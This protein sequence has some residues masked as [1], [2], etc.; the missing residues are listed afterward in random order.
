[1]AGRVELYDPTVSSNDGV[2]AAHSTYRLIFQDLPKALPESSG[3][4]ELSSVNIIADSYSQ[5]FWCALRAQARI[6]R[7]NREGAKDARKTD[8]YWNFCFPRVPRLH[9]ATTSAN[10]RVQGGDFAVNAFCCFEIV[11]KNTFTEH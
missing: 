9:P 10:A 7:M 11:S 4:Y 6:K 1:V 5:I 3:T 8:K 2:R